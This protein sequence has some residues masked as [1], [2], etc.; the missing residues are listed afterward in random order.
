MSVRVVVTVSYP[1][2]CPSCGHDRGTLA[3]APGPHA[4]QITCGGCGS[5]VKWV[6]RD[7]LARLLSDAVGRAL[8]RAGGA[9]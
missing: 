8:A 5:F 2:G 6:G 7:D 4:G 1:A 3:P 9:R